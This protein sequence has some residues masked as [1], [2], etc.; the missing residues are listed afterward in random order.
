MILFGVFGYTPK[1]SSLLIESPHKV[2]AVQWYVW[3]GVE[4]V[5]QGNSI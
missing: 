2:T 1:Y 3:A 5:E 4:K